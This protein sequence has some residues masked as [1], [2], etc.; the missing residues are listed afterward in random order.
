MVSKETYK[1]FEAHLVE[2]YLMI[3][4]VTNHF[5]AIGNA[6]LIDYSTTNPFNK[7]S[8]FHDI[9]FITYDT[10]ATSEALVDVSI[11]ACGCFV[12]NEMLIFDSVGLGTQ[13]IHCL[14]STLLCLRC[15]PST[16]HGLGNSSRITQVRSQLV[17]ISA[18]V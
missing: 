10:P 11:V 15:G 4:L 5:G 2:Q 14:M 8:Q 7:Q 18:P 16:T 17:K 6:S 3:D 9:C 1:S 12:M 13:A